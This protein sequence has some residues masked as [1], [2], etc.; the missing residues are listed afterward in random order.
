SP[1]A[2][3]RYF[4]DVFVRPGWGGVATSLVH[5]NPEGKITGFIGALARRMRFRGQ[6]LNA[7]VAT[8]LMTDVGPNRAF[9]A[10]SLVRALFA[11]PQDLT[12]SDG[13]NELSAEVWQ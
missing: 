10:F 4:E 3:M 13:A 12:F 6:P 11:G 8:Q 1:S 2:V 5:E 7:V 9:V